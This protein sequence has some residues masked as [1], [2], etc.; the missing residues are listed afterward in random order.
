M[1]I[2][3]R[4]SIAG[5]RR[6]ACLMSALALTSLVGCDSA[7]RTIDRRTEATLLSAADDVSGGTIAPRLRTDALYEG[8]PMAPDY[9]ERYRPPTRNPSA[10]DLRFTPQPPRDETLE[11]AAARIQAEG[12]P[13]ADAVELD[14]RGAIRFAIDNA[15]EYL[16]AEETYIIVALA[17]IIEQHRWEPRPFNVTSAE[18]AALGNDGRFGRTLQISNDLGVTQRLPYGGEVSARLVVDVTR[19]VDGFFTQ[20]GTAQS[21]DLILQAEIPFLRGAGIAAREELIQRSRDLIYAARSFEE[22]R[23]DFC[24]SLIRGYLDLVLQQQEIANARRQVASSRQVDQREDALVK[25]GR[26][27]PFQADLAKQNTLF[28]VNRLAGLEERYRVAVDNYKVRIGMDPTTPVVIV[29]VELDLP[30]PAVTASDAV[31]LAMQFRLDLQT[32]ADRVEDARRRVDVA[33]NQVLPDLDVTLAGVIPTIDRFGT[34]AGLN[35]R[36]DDGIYRAGASFGWAL[37]RTIERAQLRQS[38]IRYEQEIRDERLARDDAAVEVRSSLRAIELSRFSLLLQEQNVAIAMNREAS[39]AAAPDRASAR[40]RTEALDQRRQ[41]EDQ[42]DR[43]QVDLQ[44]SILD[45]LLTTGQFRV[46][47]EGLFLPVTGLEG[48][49]VI[50][51]LPQDVPGP[52]PDLGGMAPETGEQPFPNAQGVD[53]NF[54]VQTETLP[55]PDPSAPLVEPVTVPP[56][57]A[58]DDRR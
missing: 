35:L 29:P 53:G 33:A 3:S 54:P 22:F 6:I 28:A 47:P 44:I 41:A 51:T 49:E 58:G 4:P 34:N 40:D 46:T 25:A 20:E 19:Q 16:N 10:S 11:A 57:T 12:M 43:A 17:L 39:I 30:M 26:Q 8:D 23:R 31:R 5:R 1:T 52:A 37:D 21:A 9:P 38:Q 7:M 32:I 48:S 45:Y 24:F 14:L 55:V 15:V 42:R 36:P 56:A 18:F 13:P 27:P 50:G 2:A